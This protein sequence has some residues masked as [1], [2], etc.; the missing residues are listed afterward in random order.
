MSTTLAD[1]NGDG[2]KDL[3]LSKYGGGNRVYTNDGTGVLT[4]AP[5]LSTTASE[6]NAVGDFDGDGSLDILLGTRSGTDELYFNTIIDTA[7]TLDGSNNLLITDANGGASDDELTIST[8]GTVVTIFDP[9]VNLTTEIAGATD[10]GTNTVT[11]PL[12]QITGSDIIVNT[13]GG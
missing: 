8:N 6:H 3:I 1:V 2:F 7:I 10:S 4:L 13:L 9:N 12:S 5:T 11:V